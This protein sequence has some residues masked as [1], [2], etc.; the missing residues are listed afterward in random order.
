MIT[1]DD[2]LEIQ[3]LFHQGLSRSEIA[4]RMGLD[5]KTVRKYLNKSTGPPMSKPRQKGSLLDEFKEYLKKRL[6]Q[7][8]CNGAV[9]YRELKEQGAPGAH[10]DPERLLEATAPGGR[11]AGGVEV[12]IGA[13]AICAGGLGPM[14][15]A[16]TR[17]FGAKVIRL[18]LYA[19]LFAGGLRRMDQSDGS[20]HATEMP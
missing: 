11:V 18:C 20:G 12:G 14:Q 10:Y 19:G 16:I 1:L 9:L 13:R 7:G 4:R 2:Y 8:C 6:S 15:G 3:Q 17:R 5:R